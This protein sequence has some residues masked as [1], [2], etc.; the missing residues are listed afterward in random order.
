MPAFEVASIRPAL[1]AEMGGAMLCLVPCRMGSRLTV[2]GSH[3][4]FRSYAVTDLILRAY[5][6]KPYQ[7]SIANPDDAPPAIGIRW[8]PLV[9][10][11]DI[12][13]TI[14]EGVSTTRLPEMLQVL[15]AERFKLSLHRAAR[16]LPVYALM[17]G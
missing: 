5:R 1:A 6:L 7:L 13:A 10:D 15:L 3:V 8:N 14:P 17:V 4:T 9:S 16:E 11:C 12:A 2:D